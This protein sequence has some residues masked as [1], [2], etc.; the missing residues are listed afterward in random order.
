MPF[1]ANIIS[2]STHNLYHCMIPQNTGV[3]APSLFH[4]NYRMSVVDI[5]LV[6]WCISFLMWPQI[7]YVIVTQR[8]LLGFLCFWPTILLPF[9]NQRNQAIYPTH[10]HHFHP[11][12][13]FFSSIQG[14]LFMHV[15]LMLLLLLLANSTKALPTPPSLQILHI[16]TS[17][18]I[19]IL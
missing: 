1:L 3:Q 9:L 7:M 15:T 14:R 19:S 2:H 16:P 10:S 6:L 8:K 13:S 5:G 12:L 18:C 17:G 11:S 4:Q